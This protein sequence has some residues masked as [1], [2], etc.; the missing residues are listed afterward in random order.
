M[1]MVK[2]ALVD[3][4]TGAKSTQKA[5]FYTVIDRRKWQEKLEK[6]FDVKV[7]KETVK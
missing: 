5:K 2:V 7:I 6:N 1:Y 4:K 3:K